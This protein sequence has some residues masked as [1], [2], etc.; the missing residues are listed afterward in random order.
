MN[1][2]D[3]KSLTCSELEREMEKNRGEKVSGKTII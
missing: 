1:L 2:I 3:I